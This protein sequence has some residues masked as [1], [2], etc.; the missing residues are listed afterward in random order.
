MTTSQGIC[1]NGDNMT[2]KRERKEYSDFLQKILDAE[3]NDLLL[4]E[5]IEETDVNIERQKEYWQKRR[6]ENKKRLEELKHKKLS[7]ITMADIQEQVSLE[8]QL[9]DIFDPRFGQL[10]EQYG[11]LRSLEMM[12]RLKNAI[13]KLEISMRTSNSRITKL[14]WMLVLLALLQAILILIQWLG[15]K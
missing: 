7:E 10:K 1:Y 8:I 5:L 15:S 3:D 6:K 14:T 11:H 13:G 4:D 12:K 2:I 9:K